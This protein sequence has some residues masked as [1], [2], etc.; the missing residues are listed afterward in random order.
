MIDYSNP[1]EDKWF[2]WRGV[3]PPERQSHGLKEDEVEDFIAK[4]GRHK[5]EWRQKG[6]FIFCVV[7][8]HEH[9]KNIGSFKRLTGTN[10]NGDPILVDI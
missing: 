4:V 3:P 8:Q 9:G 10:E 7:G 5:H 1:Q 2:K 6:N